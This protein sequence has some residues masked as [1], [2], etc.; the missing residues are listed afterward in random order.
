MNEDRPALSATELLRTES[1]FQRR[2]DIDYV[3]IAG[4]SSARSLL[5]S[6]ND[7]IQPPYSQISRNW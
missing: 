2:I 5:V 1:T 3:D 6:E 4:R 7:D